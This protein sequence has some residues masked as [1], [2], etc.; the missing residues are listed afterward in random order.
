MIKLSAIEGLKL[1]LSDFQSAS[2]LIYKHLSP[3]P[4]LVWP[5]LSERCGCEVWTKHENHLPTGSFKVRGGIWYIDQLI[6]SVGKVPGVVAATRGNHGQSVAFSAQRN[7]IK[8]Q[9]VIPF[10]NS[11]GK[12]RAMRGYG[13]ELIEHGEDFNVALEYAQ[14]LAEKNGLHLFPS[15]HPL[16]VQG[17]GTYSLEFLQA[18]PDMHTVYVPIGLG[19]G[20][21]GMIAA[22]NALNLK[23]EIVGVVSEKAPAYALSYKNKK[24]EKTASCNTMADGLAVRIPNAL[25]LESILHGVAR[26]V[27]VSDEQI[28][29]AIQIYYTDTH[30]IAEGAGAS[31]LAALLK[32]RDR[33]KGKKTGLVLSGGNLDHNL[34]IHALRSER[35]E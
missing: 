29:E 19:S 33:M 7:G 32:E 28:I 27:T 26:V 2:S 17:V 21:C 13:A 6:N 11:P 35:S 4:Q 9:V 22:R 20:I 16:L 23:T 34:M 15:F 12:N 3:T 10:N 24:L 30:N 14:A 18:V 1:T 31:P 5:L 25:A 8:A